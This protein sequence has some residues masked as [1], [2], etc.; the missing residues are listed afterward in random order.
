MRAG[1]SWVGQRRVLTLSGTTRTLGRI[2]RS[3]A[4]PSPRGHL[5]DMA[6]QQLRVDSSVLMVGGYHGALLSPSTG[7]AAQAVRRSWR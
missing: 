6:T 2:A 3:A 4:T 5:E 7:C 1:S